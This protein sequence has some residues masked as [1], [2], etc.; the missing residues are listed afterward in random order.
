VSSAVKAL[1]GSPPARSS[2]P[3]L[4]RVRD[5]GGAPSASTWMVRR[6]I[7]IVGR[8]VAMGG[9]IAVTSAAPSAAGGSPRTGDG[10]RA[11]A[12]RAR[13]VAAGQDK[14]IRAVGHRVQHLAQHV[15]QARKLSNVRSS[16]TSSKERGGGV[17][18]GAARPI[19]PSVRSNAARADE[20]PPAAP[21]RWRRSR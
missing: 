7:A 1:I 17:A 5:V 3:R 4:R 19:T 21:R 10:R 13:D 8:G 20:R 15:A 14:T 18:T 9:S 2:P 11:A 6:G 16:S 12:V